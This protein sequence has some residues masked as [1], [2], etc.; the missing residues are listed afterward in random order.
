VH[1]FGGGPDV[2]EVTLPAGDWSVDGQLAG[3]GVET[4]IEAGVLVR[5]GL[6]PFTGGVVLLR[7]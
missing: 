7:Q 3:D 4:S 6:R 5:R 1:T 2:V